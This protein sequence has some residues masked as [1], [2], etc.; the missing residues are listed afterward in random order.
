MYVFWSY[1]T[2][3]YSGDVNRRT[4]PADLSQLLIGVSELKRRQLVPPFPGE[5]DIALTVVCWRAVYDI[6]AVMSAVQ[7]ADL[8]YFVLNYT[9]LSR[10]GSHG[11]PVCRPFNVSSLVLARDPYPEAAHLASKH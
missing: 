11:P 6:G 4:S 1:E 2:D 5:G 8:V 3:M 10:V 9:V 7:V